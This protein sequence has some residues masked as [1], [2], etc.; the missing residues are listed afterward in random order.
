MNLL[1]I[2]LPV[3]IVSL[4][5][6]STTETKPPKDFPGV[7]SMSRVEVVQGIKECLYAKLQPNVEYQV[8]KVETGTK[9]LI[10]INVHCDPKLYQ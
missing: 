4:V 9:V 7:H 5:G 1:K 3:A 2:V 8:Q 10:P 6:C